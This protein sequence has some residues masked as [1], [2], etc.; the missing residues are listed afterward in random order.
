M[1]CIAGVGGGV[2]GLVKL[3]QSGRPILALD[4]CRLSCVQACLRQAG[5]QASQALLLSDQGVVKYKHQAYAISQA[6]EVWPLIR[7]NAKA[8]SAGQSE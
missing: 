4:G 6:E 7:H 1:S 3:A 8:L 2:P 5:V